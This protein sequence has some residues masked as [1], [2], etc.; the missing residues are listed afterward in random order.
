M[1]GAAD[2]LLKCKEALQDIEEVLD[3]YKSS[4]AVTKRRRRLRPIFVPLH[5]LCVNLVE[6]MNQIQADKR[7]HDQL[8]AGTPAT[9]TELRSYFVTMVPFDRKG[10]LGILRNKVAAHYESSMSPAEMRELLNATD[11]TQV[12]EWLHL[13]ISVLCDLLKLEAY[14]WNAAGPTEETV[15]IMCQEPILSVLRIQNEKIA[16]FEGFYMRRVSPRELVQNVVRSVT[17]GSQCLF[18]RDCQYRI[19]GFVPDSL[20]QWARSLDLKRKSSE[21]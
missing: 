5:T 6:L 12:G 19:G 2:R 18:E 3:S 15:T 17:E 14:M 4:K 7:V 8:P 9:L 20:E 1:N 13:A 16:G 21:A 11:S 10:K